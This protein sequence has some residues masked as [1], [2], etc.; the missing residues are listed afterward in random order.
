MQLKNF[1]FLILV[2]VCMSVLASCQKQTSDT[3]EI[4]DK[5]ISS[6]INLPVGRRYCSRAISGDSEYM[7]PSLLASLYGNGTTPPE[8][9]EWVEYSIFISSKI[10][11]CEFA[12]FCCESNASVIDTSK[13]LL[14]RIDTLKNSRPNDEYSH[15]IENAIVITVGNYCLLIISSD[16]ETIAKVATSVIG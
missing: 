6:E 7:P 4:L 5:I 10:C 15:Y 1:S 8:S 3:S 14:R 2:C 11:P 9:D 12:V 13:M 16:A